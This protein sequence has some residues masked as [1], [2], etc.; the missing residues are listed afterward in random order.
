MRFFS[1]GS[2]YIWLRFSFW[3]VQIGSAVPKLQQFFAGSTEEM[4]VLQLWLENY[5]TYL[6]SIIFRVEKV[7]PSYRIEHRIVPIVHY[8]VGG[9]GR[10]G[11]TLQ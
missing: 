7:A 8:I 10:Q 11:I 1:V 2:Y 9:H 6:Y 3:F 5:E 4:H